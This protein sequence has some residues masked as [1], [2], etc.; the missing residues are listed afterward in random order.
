M[1]TKSFTQRG[2]LFLWIFIPIII[3]NCIRFYYHY[4]F[5]NTDLTQD[6]ILMITL[7]VVLLMMY[8]ITITISATSLGMSMGIGFIRKRYRLKDIKSITP[9]TN[10]L[11]TGWGIRYIPG[12]W[13]YNVSGRKAIEIRFHNSPK[14]IRIGTDKPE[15]VCE[16]VKTLLK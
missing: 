11:L 13:L 12:G 4:Q 10:S 9:V 16:V 8:K 2:T 1:E 15:E 5:G 7:S 6:G 14:V 3:F